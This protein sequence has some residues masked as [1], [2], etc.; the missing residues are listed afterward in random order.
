[1]DRPINKSTNLRRCEH[2]PHLAFANAEQ[3][4]EAWEAY[5][6]ELERELGELKGELE[7]A[8]D[9]VHDREDQR[10]RADKAEKM[11]RE[12]FECLATHYSR[13]TTDLSPTYNKHLDQ[14]QVYRDE[15]QKKKDS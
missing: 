14:W 3:N 13:M 7:I 6:S 9:A 10:T 12:A 8:F 1:M 2:N 4:S 5:A 11:A 15:Y